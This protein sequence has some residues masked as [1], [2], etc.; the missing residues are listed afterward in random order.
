M[1]TIA[2]SVRECDHAECCDTRELVCSIKNLGG[3]NNPNLFHFRVA[4]AD[5]DISLQL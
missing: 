2:N 4:C 1:H 5:A 3:Q